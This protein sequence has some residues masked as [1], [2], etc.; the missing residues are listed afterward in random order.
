[1]TARLILLSLFFASGCS[2]FGRYSPLRP[3]ER[4]LMFH[5]TTASA[6]VADVGCQSVRIDVNDSEQIHALFLEH[7]NPQAVLL[8]CHGNAG[9]IVDRLPRL[10]QL[11]TDHQVTVLGFDYRGY[12]SSDGKPDE[13]R[14]YEDAR[15]A[16][17]WLAQQA[18]IGRGNVVLLGRSLG[19]AIA[20]ELASS[21]GARG[22]ILE[23]TFTSM[24]EVGKSHLKFVPVS[25]IVTQKFDSVG[26]IGKYD[27]P[28]LQ[29]H[30]TRDEVVPFEQGQKLFHQAGSKR[31]LF[32][33]TQGGHND[34]PP[35]EYET[36]LARFLESLREPP[37]DS[38]TTTDLPSQSEPEFNCCPNSRRDRTIGF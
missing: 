2:A 34:L 31:K 12:G 24:T 22:L 18:G 28:L 32:H 23:S 25:M 5:P 3:L 17:N 29:T 15:A 20:V 4:K 9:N 13:Q 30:G 8:Y 14:M 27:G 7:P 35:A 33:Q 1:M 26:K 38:T 36:R 19:G 21:D 16:R 37:T 11:R 10:N 6:A